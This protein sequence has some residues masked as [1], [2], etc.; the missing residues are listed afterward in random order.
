MQNQNVDNSS[1]LWLTKVTQPCTQN[2]IAKKTFTDQFGMDLF[3]HPNKISPHYEISPH[4]K[5]ALKKQ[6]FLK[7]KSKVS[8]FGI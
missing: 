7:S 1:S 6:L 4:I 2:H 3:A 8:K 5:I